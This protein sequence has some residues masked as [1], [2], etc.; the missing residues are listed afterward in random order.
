MKKYA[1]STAMGVSAVALTMGLS[2]AQNDAAACEATIAEMNWASA[3]FIANLDK[4]VLEVG[5]GCDTE[6]VPGDTQPTGI[7]M[8]E[9]GEPDIAPELWSNAMRDQ[10]DEAVAAGTLTDAGNVFVEG[11]EEGFWVPKYMADK[12]PELTTLEGLIANASMFPHPEDDSKSAL[13]G[14]PAGWNCQISTNNLVNAL[15]LADAGFEVIDPGSG[16]GLD[17]SIAK[18]F[19]RGEAWVGY[20]WAPTA[21]M[22][23]YE[24]AKVDFGTG[25]DMDYFQNCITQAECEA[26]RGSM[27]PPSRVDTLT[28]TSFASENPE[29]FQYV[30][31]RKFN[32]ADMNRMLAWIDD[33]QADGEIAAYHFLENYEHIWSSWVPADVAEKIKAEL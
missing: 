21:M 2:A 3:G 31:T 18:A 6:L 29:A 28:T 4:I 33:N 9:K 13:M 11:G 1:L 24:M 27:Y 19:E 5:Y 25:I 26:T 23:K 10:L 32:N 20:Y 17:G 12:H 30:T 15:G 22:G 8:A 16:A 7:S 14:C